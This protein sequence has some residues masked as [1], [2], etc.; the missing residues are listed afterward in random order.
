M[1]ENEKSLLF[2]N[3]KFTISRGVPSAGYAWD[4]VLKNWIGKRLLRGLFPVTY[5]LP[6]LTLRQ[7]VEPFSTCS[8]RSDNIL[9]DVSLN[10]KFQQGI[11]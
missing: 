4:F 10:M 9:I 5:G 2:V 6:A 1:D 11:W 3:G 8:D 7:I